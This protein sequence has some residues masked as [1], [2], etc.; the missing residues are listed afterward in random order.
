MGKIAPRDPVKIIVGLVSKDEALF[1]EIKGILVKRFGPTDAQSDVFRFD[2]TSYYKAE[3]GQNLLRRFLSFKKLSKAEGI[4]RLKLFTNSVEKKFS[5]NGRRLINIDP[6][7]LTC[8]KLV[9]LTTKDYTHR[10]YINRGIYAESTLHYKDEA[11]QDWQWS[12]PDY[13]TG[14][15]KDFF[16]YIRSIYT[17]QLR[18]K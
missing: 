7:Y 5:E 16:K 14:Q 17:K 3:M 13:K 4:E 2:K 11:W 9:L 8:A 1:D 6:G 12:Y 15:Y 10:I 18:K